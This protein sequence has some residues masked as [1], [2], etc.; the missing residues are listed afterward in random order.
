MSQKARAAIANHKVVVFSKT[1]CPYCTKAKRVLSGLQARVH[2]LE[3]DT[4]SDGEEIQAALREITGVRTVPQVF[5]RGRFIG[6]GDDTERLNKRGQL[7]PMLRE[8]GAL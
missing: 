1:Y 4:M 5:I 6:G 2:V 3:L 7:E 8:A